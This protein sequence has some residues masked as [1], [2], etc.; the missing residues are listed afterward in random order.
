[1]DRN[2]LGPAFVEWET[3][4]SVVLATPATPEDCAKLIQE[5]VAAGFQWDMAPEKL[6]PAP[7][8][9]RERRKFRATAGTA[10]KSLGDSYGWNGRVLDPP[11]WSL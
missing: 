4:K 7:D 6:D 3:D 11:A 9:D 10:P 8:P 2:E 5:I 1:M